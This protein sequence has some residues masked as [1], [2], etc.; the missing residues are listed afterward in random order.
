MKSRN[1][2]RRKAFIS[3][4]F[5]LAAAAIAFGF[6]ARAAWG[7]YGKAAESAV[8]LDQARSE[9]ARVEADRADLAAK[10]AGLSTSAGVETAMRE[11]YHAAEP[12]ES[13]A[14]IVD[15]GTSQTAAVPSS[16][17]L[18]S[19]TAPIQALGWWQRLLRAI[20]LR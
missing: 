19:S 2:F 10:V 14:V 20:G 12:G 3:S 13:V 5:V 15:S 7:I 18:S 9:L 16:D 8:R 6:L 11:K 17:Q 1:R 4:P